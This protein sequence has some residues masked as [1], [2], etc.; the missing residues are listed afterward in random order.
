L[1]FL[2]K[3]G[4]VLQAKSSSSSIWRNRP[5]CCWAEAQRLE[6]WSVRKLL[7]AVGSTVDEQMRLTAEESQ[8]ALTAEDLILR[9]R[10]L[11][12]KY[13]GFGVG[14]IEC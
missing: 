14:T 8:E 5:C 13:F 12:S 1:T 7:V 4:A 3:V 9:P 2:R 6:G 10:A 11:A